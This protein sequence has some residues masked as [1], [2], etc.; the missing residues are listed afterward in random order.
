MTCFLEYP[1]VFRGSAATP[2]ALVAVAALLVSTS[3][4]FANAPPELAPL[5]AATVA[6]GETLRVRVSPSDP[7]GDVPGVRMLDW[8]HN[9]SFDDNGDGTRTLVW[10]PGVTDVGER[11]VRF[12]AVDA[13]DATLVQQRTLTITVEKGA[14]GD[15]GVAN[16]P[17]VFENL[18]DQSVAE[19]GRFSFRVAPT[20]PDGQVPGV[21]VVDAPDTATFHDNGDGSRQFVWAPAADAAAETRLTFVATDAFDPTVET[22]ATITLTIGTDEPETEPGIE[23]DTETPPDDTSDGNSPPELIDL[24]DQFA[25]LGTDFEFVVTPFDNDGT[26][27]GLYIEGL[28]VGASFD[29]NHDGTRTFRWSPLPADLGETVI[30]VVAV[31]AED[32]SL[33][34][35]QSVRLTV[36]RDE[37]NPV[38]FEPHVNG[39]VNP[40]IR[41]GD[42]LN[43]TVRG[44]DPD[45]DIPELVAVDIP[46]SA[47][48]IH[49]GGD[50]YTLIWP[51]QQSDIGDTRMTFRAVD[52]T[53]PELFHERTITVTVADPA[54]FERPGKRLRDLA[55]ERGLLVGY[56][57]TLNSA[58]IADNE[59]Y[60][61]IAAEEFNIVTPENSHK[62]GWIW[63][64]RDVF[65]WDDADHLAD[66]A[67]ANGMAL[68]G[69]PLIWYAQLPPWV[70]ALEGDEVAPVLE[71]YIELLA[72][73]YV[74]R[75][76][77]WDVVNE[78]FEK[79]GSFRD[80]VW[81]RG[82]G[83]EYIGA[84]FR[85]AREVDPT[86]TLLYNDYDVAWEG[87][88]SNAMY[89]MIKRELD[90]GTPIDG[91]GFQ[92][93]VWSHFD[94][95]ESVRRNFQRFADLGL[96]IYITETDVRI[97]DGDDLDDQ[98]NAY[99]EIMRICLDQPACR[100]FQTWG[101]T[102]R[103]SWFASAKPLLFTER[104]AM[105]PAYTALQDT[106]ENH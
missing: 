3:P 18:G 36:E 24:E 40:I 16:Q 19:G 78:A 54:D 64:A 85:K 33:R 101:F 30:T 25:Y 82:M 6:V 80:S 27:P 59:L 91:V 67:E 46:A 52:A 1:R 74:G 8:L 47:S 22:R 11:N 93:H 60:A 87:P 96:D 45:G 61:A 39:I 37:E 95:F 49:D 31:D 66:F 72:G 20:D 99:A 103:Y 97:N 21:R 76:A 71:E 90:A 56:A 106:L 34:T 105:K 42:T 100:G 14:G 55:D 13:V 29:D 77:M 84:A 32:S 62:M 48:F 65:R 89:E 4:A 35:R 75:V 51:T 58:T 63:P 44:V 68:H 5:S 12:E 41:V 23:T 69:H 10:T 98:A 70:K 53:D 7:D 50:T 57:A 92:M 79:D 94:D 104:Y 83:E 38:N 17:P 2:E 88:K 9:A 102:D 73:R 43:Q 86:A 15:G 28:P 26:V 81:Y